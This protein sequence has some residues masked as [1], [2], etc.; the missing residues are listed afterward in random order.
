[1]STRAFPP[2]IRFSGLSFAYNM[3]Y[4]VFGGLTPML[5]GAWLEKRQWQE[6][7]MLQLFLH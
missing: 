1:M 2:S 7:I 5:T 6:L 3:A 4:A